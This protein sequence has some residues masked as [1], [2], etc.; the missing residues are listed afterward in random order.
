MTRCHGERLLTVAVGA[1]LV[2]VVD[3]AIA[4]LFGWSPWIAGGIA[5][6]VGLVIFTW[7]SGLDAD[8]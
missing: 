1:T 8:A 6:V 3:G 2:A 5:F 4:D 7:L